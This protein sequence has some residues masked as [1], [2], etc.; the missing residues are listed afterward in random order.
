MTIE[1]ILEVLIPTSKTMH[2]IPRLLYC[3][4]N[5]KLK[6]QIPLLLMKGVLVIYSCG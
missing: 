2:S 3:E 5:R 1:L 4:V 6:L